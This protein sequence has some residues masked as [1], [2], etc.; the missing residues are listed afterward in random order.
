MESACNW[1]LACTLGACFPI[2]YITITRN[3]QPALLDFP[4]MLGF[5]RGMPTP[6]LKKTLL[7]AVGGAG[8]ILEKYFGRVRQIR[9]KGPQ[10]SVVC[11]ADLA[12]EAHIRKVILSRFPDASILGEEEG[13]RAGSS[14]YTWVADPLDGTSNFVAR[15]PWFGT[16][17]GVLKNHQPVMAAMYLPVEG[18]LYFAERGRGLWKNGKRLAPSGETELKKILCAFGFDASASE[19]SRSTACRMMVRVAGAVRNTRATNSLVDFCYT[20]E[21]H[22]GGCVNL[23]CKIWD[24]VPA[25]AMFPEIGG[26]FTDLT[27]RPIDF[28]LGEKDP[29]HTY[30]IVGAGKRLHAALLKV[31]RS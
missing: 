31:M 1:K 11:E 8:D 17:I 15:L 30:Q 12:A 10:A 23:N 14:E 26:K 18:T 19:R 27:G 16:Q 4:R 2:F 20:F 3:Q 25:A 22:F 7:Q 28:R 6:D 9:Q 21:G 29:A 13:M 24:I 5:A